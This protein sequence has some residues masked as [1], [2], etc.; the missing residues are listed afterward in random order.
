MQRVITGCLFSWMALIC[1]VCSAQ[2]DARSRS[3]RSAP[4]IN[5]AAGTGQR[6]MA[7]GDASSHA[8]AGTWWH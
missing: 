2:T 7:L 4:R 5:L 6:T 3:Q 1:I 8:T